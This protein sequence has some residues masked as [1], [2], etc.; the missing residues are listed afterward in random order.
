MDPDLEV[1]GGGGGGVVVFC[2]LLCWLS[3][4]P[5]ISSF[6]PKTRGGGRA[7]AA[8]LLELPLFSPG[9]GDTPL[10]FGHFGFLSFL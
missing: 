9:E 3:F 1:S 5:V 10:Y 6:L 4:G 8:P 7:R 2:C